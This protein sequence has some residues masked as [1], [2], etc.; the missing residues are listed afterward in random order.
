MSSVSRTSPACDGGGATGSAAVLGG[1]WTVLAITVLACWESWHWYAGRVAGTPDEALTLLM[2]M[3][4]ILALGARSGLGRAAADPSV[5]LLLPAALL[6]S[7]AALHGFG[8]PIVLAAIAV[9]ASLPLFYRAVVGE[10]PPLALYALAAL[11]LPVLPSLQFVLGYPMRLISAS[12]TVGLLELQ[13]LA[14]VREGTHLLFAG[15]TVEFDA[16]CSGIRMLWAGLMLTLAAC[17]IWRSGVVMTLIAVSASI[18]MTLAA[19][20]FR[21]SSLFYVEAGLLPG[22]APWWHEAIG[23]VAF[24][25][26][27]VATVLVLAR[28]NALEVRAWRQ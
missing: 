15:Q 17:V 3:G 19:N 21:A 18:L 27:A 5:P 6:A 7:Y 10:R 28:L 13:G 2:T 26:S 9:M 25:I 20:V 1:P 23:L 12:L 4:L 24:A 8:P 16:P 14:V 22:A 11:S